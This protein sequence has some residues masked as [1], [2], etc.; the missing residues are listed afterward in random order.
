[1]KYALIWRTLNCWPNAESVGDTSPMTGEEN[2]FGVGSTR[3][4]VSVIVCTTEGC[5]DAMS[6]ARRFLGG[7]VKFGGHEIVDSPVE[8][9]LSYPQYF[10]LFR[11][12]LMDVDGLDALLK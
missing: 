12:L 3:V 7:C 6:P 11:V 5:T 1:M 2:G 9:S 8:S 4:A 10:G